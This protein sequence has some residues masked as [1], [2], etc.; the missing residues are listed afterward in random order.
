MVTVEE[1][2]VALE[3][4]KAL[5]ELVSREELTRD[6]LLFC[7]SEEIVELELISDELLDK[8]DD[9]SS[10]VVVSLDELAKELSKSDELLE[11]LE[12]DVRSRAAKIAKIR[13]SGVFFI[14]QLL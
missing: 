11:P 1:L 2:L 13:T 9:D 8:E 5:D 4:L 14:T 10:L 12:Q 3:L 6:E 7:L